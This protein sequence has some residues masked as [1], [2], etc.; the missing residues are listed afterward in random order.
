MS[1][2]IVLQAWEGVVEKIES[3][4]FWAT[5]TER[6]GPDWH[7]HFPFSA[8][9]KDDLELI[10]PGAVFNWE[11]RNLGGD[12][13]VSVIKFRRFPVWTKEELDAAR[14]TEMFEAFKEIGEGASGW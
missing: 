4:S 11:I 10:L 13:N 6:S 8:V 2:A 12:S 1:E 14:A 7:A 5:L 9:D 3:D